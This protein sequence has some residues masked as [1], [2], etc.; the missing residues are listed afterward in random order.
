MP[1]GQV[2]EQDETAKWFGL[3]E[4]IG[5]SGSICQIIETSRF[6]ELMEASRVAYPDSPKRQYPS[7]IA[8]VGDTSAG[9]STLSKWSV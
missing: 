4:E 2:F 7:M 9:K 8:F 6:S 3:V 5:R 1:V